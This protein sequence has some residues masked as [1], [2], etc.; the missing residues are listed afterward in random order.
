MALTPVTIGVLLAVI[1]VLVITSAADTPANWG[2]PVSARVVDV[3]VT[4]HVDWHPTSGSWTLEG[5]HFSEQRST[6]LSW[7]ALWNNHL[8]ATSESEILTFTLHDASGAVA[9]VLTQ[10]TGKGSVTDVFNSGHDETVVFREIKP[11][12]YDLAVTIQ[13]GAGSELAYTNSRIT[14]IP[15]GS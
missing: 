6:W 15:G 12:V 5:P 2:K 3:M 9:A 10:H 4:S 8:A 13:D 11:G 14:I 7:S 1:G